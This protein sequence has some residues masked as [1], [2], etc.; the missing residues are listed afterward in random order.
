MSG[1]FSVDIDKY[2]FLTPLIKKKGEETRRK[3]RLEGREEGAWELVLLQLKKRF[4]RLPASVTKR[5]NTLSDTQAKK[6]ALA[7]LDAKSLKDLFSDLGN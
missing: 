5:V 2:T 7:I 1:T 3:G 4:G 6:L